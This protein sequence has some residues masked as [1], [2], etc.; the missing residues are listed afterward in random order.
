MVKIYIDGGH[1]GTDGGAQGNGLSEKVLTLKIAQEVERQL[2]N[3]DNVQTKMSRTS[4][5]NKTLQARTTEANNW[6]ADIFLSIHINSATTVSANGF[7]TH[8]H[9]EVPS[10]TISLQNIMHQEIMNQI[11]GVRDRGKKRSNFHVLRETNMSAILTENLFIVNK[12]DSELLKQESFLKKLAT[13]HVIGLE[14]FLGLRKVAND[15]E[16]QAKPNGAIYKVQI[17][18]FTDPKN[19]NEL[20]EKA[21]KL[22]FNVFID[23]Q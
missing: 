10:K 20:A 19:A 21:K 6:G 5:Y 15:S 3:Y 23:E 4:D 22:G 7:E 9:T 13:G 12:A 8:I 1:G 16:P 18:A 14:K 11:K 17:G 2:K